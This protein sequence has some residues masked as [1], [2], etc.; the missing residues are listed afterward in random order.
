M[1]PKSV[2]SMW[3]RSGRTFKKIVLNYHKNL[4][5]PDD[6]LDKELDIMRTRDRGQ[7]A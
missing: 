3:L 1:R 6:P 7:G 4:F 2:W 5:H